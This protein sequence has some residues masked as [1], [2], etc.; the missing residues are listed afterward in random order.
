MLQAQLDLDACKTALRKQTE[1]RVR[2]EVLQE[3]EAAHAWLQRLSALQEECNGLV[4]DKNAGQREVLRLKNSLGVMEMQLLQ[5]KRALEEKVLAFFLFS[6]CCLEFLACF[7][8]LFFSPSPPCSVCLPLLLCR[9]V[10]KTKQF[11]IRD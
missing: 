2:T 10:T 6:S 3:E 5:A 7:H 4:Q 11:C 9:R 1:Q 8:F